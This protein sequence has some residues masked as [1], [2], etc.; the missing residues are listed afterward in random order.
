[1]QL[2]MP[3]PILAACLR[4]V[5]LRSLLL[6]W[7]STMEL[8]KNLMSQVN[9][10]AFVSADVLQCWSLSLHVLIGIIATTILD[11]CVFCRHRPSSASV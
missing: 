1:M 9:L 3:V 4:R 11:H 8:Q 5:Q 6:C 7:C 10:L 2:M